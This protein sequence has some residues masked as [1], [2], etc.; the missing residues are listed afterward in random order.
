MRRCYGVVVASLLLAGCGGKPSD[1]VPEPDALLAGTV[2]LVDRREAQP[3]WTVPYG[4]EFWRTGEPRRDLAVGGPAAAVSSS[5]DV[6]DIIDRVSHS[7]A[8]GT[9]PTFATASSRAYTATFD[10]RGLQFLE[11]S[12]SAEVARIRTRSIQQGGH[13]LLRRDADYAWSVFGNTAQSRL[14]TE[15]KVVEHYELRDAGVELAWVVSERPIGA[16]DLVFALAVDGLAFAEQSAD[17]LHY[18]DSTGRRRMRIGAAELVDSRGQRWPLV[19]D[20][21]DGEP[22]WTVPA[23]VLATATYPIAIDPLIGPEIHFE[24]SDFGTL[25]TEPALASNGTGYLLVWRDTNEYEGLDHVW[26]ALLAPDGTLDQAVL[27]GAAL[28]YYETLTQ[29]AVASNGH[30]Y[31]VI[32]RYAGTGETLFATSI[33]SQGVNEG[34]IGLPAQFRPQSPRVAS[35]GTGYL[36]AWSERRPPPS[37]YIYGAR[38]TAHGALVDPGSVMLSPSTALSNLYDEGIASAGGQ[39]LVNWATGG[40]MVTS[41]GAITPS[42]LTGS[43]VASNGSS[44]LLVDG[45]PGAMRG[46]LVSAGGTPAGAG[47]FL[48]SSAADASN[49]MAASDGSSFLALWVQ[50]PTTGP[51]ALY[52][53]FVSAQGVASNPGGV[54]IASDFTDRA[55]LALSY[56]SPGYLLAWTD[57]RHGGSVPYSTIRAARISPQGI[58]LDAIPRVIAPGAHRQSAPSVAASAAGYLVAWSDARHLDT[59]DLDIRGARVSPSGTLLD[60]DGLSISDAPGP[61]LQPS[62]ASTG[63][64]YYVA[65]E[66]ARA[67]TAGQVFG[68][69]VTAQGVVADAAGVRVAPA[70]STAF[71]PSVASN[72]TD[73]FVAWEDRGVGG[74]SN[75]R[76]AHVSAS[77]VVAPSVTLCSAANAQLAP[78]AAS[79]GN[80]YLVAW[81]DRRTSSDA[82]VFATVV[83]ADGTVFATDGVA[84]STDVGKQQMPTA[85]AVGDDYLVAYEDGPT[86]VARRVTGAGTV[87]DPSAIAIAGGAA[88]ENPTAGSDG[89]RY[90]VAY[91][92]SVFAR[93]EA[94]VV[95]PGGAVAGRFPV[96][97]PPNASFPATPSVAARAGL[98]F[99]VSYV[100]RHTA[101]ARLVMYACGNSVLETDERCDDGNMTSSD[102]CSGLCAIEPG[103]TCPSV[104]ACSD[105]DECANHTANCTGICTNTPG[106]FTCSCPAGSVLGPDGYTCTTT[107]PPDAGVPDAALDAPVPDAAP[108]APVPDAALDAPVPDAAPDAPS[109]AAPDGP[110]DSLLDA[111]A[112]A[113]TSPDA[114]LDA[115]APDAGLLDAT[116]A[117][118]AAMPASGDA[119]HGC[120][121]SPGGGGLVVAFALVGLCRRRRRG[122]RA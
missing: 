28:Y 49:F 94:T 74:D 70:V 50:G 71:A 120:Q 46:Q 87:L 93:V 43:V 81:D 61:Q 27:V 37:W 91:E 107:V 24:P 36:V 80:N 78:S 112:D 35:D 53:T 95:S 69:R 54:V 33:T 118:D 122:E 110:P 106:S 89:T 9:T 83:A 8:P 59:T 14:T 117:T 16:T 20:L 25:E 39:Y 111:A 31:L 88:V 64:G 52:G 60:V 79:N 29:P 76:G 102:G 72:G 6:G 114:V 30:D 44:Y 86:V 58:V 41:Q 32:Y 85:A 48:L 3:T 101:R 92:R 18:A 73:Y 57:T 109:D 26:G 51:R 56:A 13:E 105:V 40:V 38:L 68:A 7:L 99:L 21:H 97:D 75:I 17:G 12:S 121:S 62:A 84:I 115:A 11:R 103:F 104:G 63:T 113:D 96:D 5:I 82:D 66:D 22:Q 90:L 45:T 55:D 108:D 119:D 77:N 65:W 1:G 23:A 10:G 67:G 116:G 19:A 4:G 47:D 100:R 98:P 42:S 15:S 34:T 2:S